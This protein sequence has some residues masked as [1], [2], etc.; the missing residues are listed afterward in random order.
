MNYIQQ[1]NVFNELS[2]V[3]N[4]HPYTRIVY[5]TLLDINNKCLWAGEFSA[6]NQRLMVDCAIGNEKT[7]I[8]HRNELIRENLIEF[9]PGRKGKPSRYKIMDLTVK[10]TGNV[11][12]NPTV[13]ATVN[14]TVNPTPFPTDIS[15][16]KRKHKQAATRAQNNIGEREVVKQ[17]FKDYQNRFGLLS[18]TGMT[19]LV[20]M[21]DDFGQTWVGEALTQASDKQPGNVLRY[22]AATLEGWIR[23]GYTKE[24]PVSGQRSAAAEAKAIGGGK[25]MV[26]SGCRQ[27]QYDKIPF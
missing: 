16:H 27:D 3:R 7:F 26:S 19:E 22:M 13:K 2:R 10:F 5:Y 17:V 11:T 4:L 23:D 24:I 8:L 6:T 14:P 21:V 20:S 9:L 15:K 25:R 12:V 18:Q 1:L